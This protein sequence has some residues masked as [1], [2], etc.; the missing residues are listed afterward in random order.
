M[1]NKSRQYVPLNFTVFATNV[2]VLNDK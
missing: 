1:M 2:Q